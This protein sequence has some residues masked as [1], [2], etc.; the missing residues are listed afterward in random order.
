MCCPGTQPQLSSI[1]PV[2]TSLS[3]YRA[4][5]IDYL[6]D[7]WV[8]ATATTFMTYI[9]KCCLLVLCLRFVG[10]PEDALGWAAIVAVFSLVQGITMLPIT[11]G[12]VGVAEVALV[13]MLAPIAG[14][15]YVNEVAAGVLLYRLATWL[16]IIPTGLGALGVWKFNQRRHER[17]TAAV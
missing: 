3:T 10:I 8:A 5:T 9:T 17:Q 12:S 16:L 1:L 6:R 11:P 4:E 7:K 2:Q 13:G 14:Q 15:D